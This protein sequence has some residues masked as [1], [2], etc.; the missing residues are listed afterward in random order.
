MSTIHARWPTNPTSYKRCRNG[1]VAYSDVMAVPAANAATINAW[2]NGING[3]GSPL[4][5]SGEYGHDHSGGHFG[6]PIWR[7]VASLSLH[8]PQGDPDLYYPERFSFYQ[9]PNE[10]GGVVST[11]EFS[12]TAIW[13]PP[14]DPVSGAYAKLGITARF[15]IVST[16]LSA[17]D[18]IQMGFTLG[19]GA[20]VSTNLS[21]P[22]LSG[23]R[24]FQTPSLSDRIA[25]GRVGAS[26]LVTIDM[27]VTRAAGGVS[28]GCRV[29]VHEIEFGVYQ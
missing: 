24:S 5:P 2:V 8:G 20:R 4:N 21:N 6:R 17:S 29:D 22:N 1:E 14:C 11:A 28:R 25:P 15:N 16:N 18:S 19:D 27:V 26:N 9:V 23:I 10:A 7:S 13:V 12:P 3:Y